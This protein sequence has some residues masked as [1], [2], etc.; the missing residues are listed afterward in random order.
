MLGLVG[1]TSIGLHPTCTLPHSNK[2]PS[3]AFPFLALKLP[4]LRSFRTWLALVLADSLWAD[5]RVCCLH[6]CIFL[7]SRQNCRHMLWDFFGTSRGMS[8]QI[9]VSYHYIGSGK[10]FSTSNVAMTSALPFKRKN[11]LVLLMAS[12]RKIGVWASKVRSIQQVQTM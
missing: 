1:D 12:Q 4:S 8:A 6:V 11:G 5:S 10:H 2:P 3:F 9:R 7:C